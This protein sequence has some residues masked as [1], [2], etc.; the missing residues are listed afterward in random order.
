MKRRR[1]RWLGLYR[2][3]ISSSMHFAMKA[4]RVSGICCFA[5]SS[6]YT[7]ATPQCIGSSHPSPSAEWQF[8]SSIL[9]FHA[10][11]VSRFPSRSFWRSSTRSSRAVT[12][13]VPLP[14]R[15][16][17]KFGLG[18]SRSISRATSTMPFSST[19]PLPAATRARVE[20]FQP[21]AYRRRVP[22]G[23]CAHDRLPS[24][25][26]VE[27]RGLELRGVDLTLRRISFRPIMARNFCDR[28]GRTERRTGRADAWFMSIEDDGGWRWVGVKLEASRAD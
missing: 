5:D 27:A 11:F 16:A 10:G 18:S 12:L 25:P 19:T 8:L 17:D 9:L 26:R 23:S 2:S 13:S 4:H 14:I 28:T 22:A 7:L 15:C 3:T 20:A 1:G 6:A 21:I 24:D